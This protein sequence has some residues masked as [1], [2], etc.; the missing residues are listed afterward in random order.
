MSALMTG[1]VKWFND[2]RGFGFIENDRGPDIFIHF[3][4]I[5]SDG[6][7]TLKEREKVYYELSDGGK[8]PYASRLIRTHITDSENHAARLREV[9]LTEII[10]SEKSPAAEST[11]PLDGLAQLALAAHGC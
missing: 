6:Y 11:N 4:V 8:G 1:T 2:Q 7:K 3:S 5:E 10:G 9:S